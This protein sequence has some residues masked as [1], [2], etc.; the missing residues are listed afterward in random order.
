MHPRLE[1]KPAKSAG[2]K[3][4]WSK[5]SKPY[6]RRLL[7]GL[8]SLNQ[9][10][11]SAGLGWHVINSGKARDVDDILEQF[12]RGLRQAGPK[13]SLRLAKHGVLV[14]QV[15]RPRLKKSLQN[16]WEALK[17]WEES[18]PTS[19]RAPMPLPLLAAV[20]CHARVLASKSRDEIERS[21][22][23]TF[24]TLV[25]VGFY[26]LLRPGELLNIAASDVSLPNS[27]TLGGRFAVIKISRPK[28]ARQMGAQQFVELRHAD[29]V[30]WLAWVKL[31]RNSN[32]PFWKNSANKFRYMFR[33]VCASL[34]IAQLHLTPASL[35]AGGATWLVDQGLEINR[36]R[37]LG[38]WAH[39]RSLEHYIQVARA[40]QIA[41]NIPPHVVE[42][43]RIFL[44]K[45]CF[46]LS[47][48]CFFKSQVPSE[49]LIPSECCQIPHESD[50]AACLRKWG[51]LE[52]AV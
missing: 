6:Q 38:R 50:A 43:L 19:F 52:Q 47:L 51:R 16:T 15:M 40:Q 49:S 36:I 3:L 5:S 9:F 8:S 25:L 10:L 39:L 4:R 30:N 37:F 42:K 14:I 11:Q 21:R 22:W 23:F 48:P 12:V 17:S 29:T 32:T 34:Q 46:L 18:L 41:L 1:L 7:E 20:V 24:A 33:Q 27:L 45:S 28:K 35:R 44:M 26:G 31:T 13:S 2:W